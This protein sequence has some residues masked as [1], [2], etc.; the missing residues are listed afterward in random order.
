MRTEDTAAPSPSAM[1]PP[2]RP[3][4]GRGA[5][6]RVAKGAS[7]L[8]AGALLSQI[9]YVL[10]LPVATRFY[11]PEMFGYF[12]SFSSFA[13]IFAF[14]GVLTYQGVFFLLSKPREERALI[15][16]MVLSAT[17][18][19]AIS[20]LVSI[21]WLL[22]SPQVAPIN[23]LLFAALMVL[24]VWPRSLMVGFMAATV[25]R[26]NLYNASLAN[27]VRSIAIVSVWLVPAFFIDRTSEWLLIGGF[28]LGSWAG[29]CVLVAKPL[30]G[31][32]PEESEAERRRRP[33]WREIWSL[34]TKYWEFPIYGAPA[35][36]LRQ[37]TQYGPIMIFASL[38]GPAAAGFV[39]LATQA[40]IRPTTL[41]MQSLGDAIRKE[42][43]EKL[44][45]QQTAGALRFL[46]QAKLG[47]AVL[48][49]L[50]GL[51]LWAVSSFVGEYLLPDDWLAAAPAL[52]AIA[53]RLAAMVLIRPTIMLA[54]LSRWQ[55]A[56]LTFEVGA[57]VVM[58]AAIFLGWWMGMDFVANLLVSS[59]AFAVV[60]V[61]FVLVMVYVQIGDARRELALKA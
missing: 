10:A 46:L 32:D 22:L 15:S 57:L 11:S 25:K 30:S 38:Y 21:V 19:S 1:P 50:A 24:A 26:G 9:I 29:L 49:T 52:A 27:I 6:A 53:P 5:A 12:G 54:S 18:V 33:S 48:G 39:T 40:V 45:N 56:I 58:T 60:G 23:G 31:R 55:G 42:Y 59:I 47:F 35:V 7:I 3:K 8:G 17:L 43:G 28:M 36:L 13:G 61:L 51:G 34:A 37:F 4:R 41:V 20:A 44:R 14:T 16:L 2:I